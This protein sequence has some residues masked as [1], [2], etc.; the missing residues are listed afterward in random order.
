MLRRSETPDI[1]ETITRTTRAR[2]RLAAG[3]TPNLVLVELPD[4]LIQHVLSFSL[5]V[6]LSR[7]SCVSH[8]FNSVHVPLAIPLRCALLGRE[9]LPQ[10]PKPEPPLRTLLFCETVAARPPC[11]ISADTCH[12]M[13]IGDDGA[14]RSWGGHEQ[15]P[16]D[17]DDEWP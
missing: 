7:L 3:L 1:V 4:S 12:T 8:D 17:E 14:V 16:D 5:A 2:A 13:A 10:P 6:D 15:G 11:T 9:H